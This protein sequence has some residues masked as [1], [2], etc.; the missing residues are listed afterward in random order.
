MKF[1]SKSIFWLVTFDIKNIGIT[2]S[3]DVIL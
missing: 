1:V 2:S 3:V